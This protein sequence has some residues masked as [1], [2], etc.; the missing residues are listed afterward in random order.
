[1]PENNRKQVQEELEDLQLQ[2]AREAAQQRKSA[3]D[4]KHLRVGA[5]EES[6]RRD[7]EHQKYIQSACHHKKGGKGTAQLYQGSDSNYAIVVHTLSH[8]PTVV[9]CQRCGKRWEPPERLAKTAT[10]A[11]RLKYREDLTE[12]R[13]ALNLP[14]DNEPSGTVLFAFSEADENAAFVTA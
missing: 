14:T 1:M 2:E 10:P 9:I 8:G 6:L 5:I 3:R 11:E 12:Y 4:Q 13:W 7:R